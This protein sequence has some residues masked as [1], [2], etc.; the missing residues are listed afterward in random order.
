[1]RSAPFH[2]IG[3]LKWKFFLFRSFICHLV[4]VILFATYPALIVLCISSLFNKEQHPLTIQPSQISCSFAE[5][6][7]L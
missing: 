3:E 6:Q 7:K 1:M 5:L 2:P 4:L